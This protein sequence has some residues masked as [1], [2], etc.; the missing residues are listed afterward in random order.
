MKRGPGQRFTV[1]V[2]RQG[3]NGFVCRCGRRWVLVIAVHELGI[4]REGMVTT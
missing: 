2:E 1:D 3:I 4:K